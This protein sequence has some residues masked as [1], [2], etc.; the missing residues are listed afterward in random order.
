MFALRAHLLSDCAVCICSSSAQ[1]SSQ[2]KVRKRSHI[3]IVL[4]EVFCHKQHKSVS[5]LLSY[6]VNQKSGCEKTEKIVNAVHCIH[7]THPS[8]WK[9]DKKAFHQTQTQAKQNKWHLSE[10]ESF[11]IVLA[12]VCVCVGFDFSV[13]SVQI[14]FSRLFCGFHFKW[15]HSAATATA[16]T[17]VCI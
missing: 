6:D 13:V 3:K 7:I 12:D 4:F 17:S 2:H 9:E 10:K 5:T 15:Q 11:A 8:A 1:N 14:Q 16:A